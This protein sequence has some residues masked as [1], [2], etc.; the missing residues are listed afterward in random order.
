MSCVDDTPR[1]D[2]ALTL[3]QNSDPTK[4]STLRRKYAQ[5][6]RGQLRKL[7]AAI[8]RGVAEQDVLD[9]T[10]N[11]SEPPE[12]PPVFRFPTDEG[13]IDAFIKWL[14]DQ[15][16]RGLLRVISRDNNTFI[17]TAYERGIDHAETGLTQAG[18]D[19]QHLPESSILNR[20]I[21]R[22]ELQEL[23]TRNYEYLEGISQDLSDEIRDELTRGFKE[24]WNPRKMARSLTD[25]VNRIGKTRATVMARTE[26][27]NA[28]STATLNR[29]EETGVE[30]VGITAEFSDS[31]DDRVCPIC[32][33]LDGEVYELDEARN[34]TF[35]FDP[36]DDDPD[37]LAGEY[38]IKPPVHPQCRCSF[39]PVVT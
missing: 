33:T 13:Y 34:G 18:I 9:L 12:D 10:A 24:G 21:H 5:R 6:L 22:D 8:R 14:D 1:V 29:F 28:H 19:L 26:T 16:S 36:G 27:I 17:R 35:E 25:R 37:L 39:I 7:N 4:T 32:E 38:A 11:D 20:P 2:G 3:S 31:D 30:T 23:Y 15:L